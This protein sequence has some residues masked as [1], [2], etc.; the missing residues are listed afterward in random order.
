MWGCG[1]PLPVGSWVWY[2]L[3]AETCD[4]THKV[5]PTGK[6]IQACVSRG[7]LRVDQMK[8]LWLKLSLQLSWRP[9]KYLYSSAPLGVG[10]DGV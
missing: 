4:N 1:H 5:L 2:L 10:T 3:L 7:L 8:S 9:S 6:L